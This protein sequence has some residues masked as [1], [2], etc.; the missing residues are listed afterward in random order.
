MKKSLPLIGGIAL[1][2]VV[3][4]LPMNGL[5]HQAQ[6]ALAILTWAIVWWIFKVLPDFVT[7]MLMG[8][9][10]VSLSDAP[11]ATVCSA[12]SGSTWWLLMT[13]FGLSLG[14][15][16]CGVLKRMSLHLLQLFPKSFFGQITGLT[17]VGFVSAPFIPSLSAKS[18]ML[19]PL[20]LGISDSIGYERKGKQATGLFIAMLTGLRTPALLFISASPIGYALISHYPDQISQQFTMGKWFLSALPW[21]IISTAATLSVIY[22]LYKPSNG[23]QS[24]SGNSADAMASLPLMSKNEKFMTMIICSALFLWVTESIHGISAHLVAISALCLTIATGTLSVKEFCS[25]MNWDSIIFIGFALGIASVFSELQINTWIVK[26]F[27]PVFSFFSANPVV[28]L[29]CIA[30]LTVLLR[31]VI[32]SE[33]AFIN[34]I[35]AFLIP[36]AETMGINPWVVGLTVYSVISPWFFL[37]QNPVYMAAYHSVKGEMINHGDIVPFCLIY[38]IICIAAIVISVPYW[39]YT[40]VFYL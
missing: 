32:V 39:I 27:L 7:A 35:M 26:I 1:G 33:M 3:M 36:L 17:A 8:V 15:S 21:F 31:F 5:T 40:G 20:S 28:F 34:I 19:A 37:Y 18:A 9:L 4:F 25:E 11:M 14:I 38:L 2:L 10:F 22:L 6:A 29:I 13:A 23:T 30:V 16:K 24:Q 12:F